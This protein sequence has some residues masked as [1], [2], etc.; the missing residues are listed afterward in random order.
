MTLG[1][2]RPHTKQQ[3]PQGSFYCRTRQS[4]C[5]VYLYWNIGLNRISNLLLRSAAQA[6]STGN[7]CAAASPTEGDSSLGQDP[8]H[9][10]IRVAR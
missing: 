3:F 8:V 6:S 1:Y 2:L 7:A 4:V 9:K 10:A 5:Q